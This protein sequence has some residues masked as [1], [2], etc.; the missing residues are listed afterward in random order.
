MDLGKRLRQ[1][2]EE[3]GLTQRQLCGDEITRNM[4]SQ[5]EHGTARPS[6]TTLQ[7][8]AARLKKPVSYFLEEQ[9]VT[10]P[11]QAAMT[12]ARAAYAAGS[13]AE[14]VAALAGYQAPDAVFDW[15][16]GLLLVL[17]R[18]D[19]AE[20][21]IKEGRLPYAAVLLDAVLQ[22][23]QTTPYYGPELERKRLLLLAKARPESLAEIVP[24]LPADD[25]E[26]LVRAR[27]ALEAGD[28]LRC[29]QLLEGAEDRKSGEWDL[30]RGGAYIAQKEPARAAAC[31]RLAEE[32]Y[33]RETAPLL[34]KC[35]RELEDY[36]MAYYYACLQLRN[37]AE[38]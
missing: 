1:A 18:L 10:S 6:M 27:A 20:A 22:A 37:H 4:L 29:A 15:E 8:L 25:R 28:P 17:G 31:Y 19:M 3:I 36:K 2:R 24:S 9:A 30:L 35:Y 5:I 32:T 23:G 11:N 34:E 14:T 16:A 21:A 33:P 12:A 7:Y 38:N 26:L 13:G